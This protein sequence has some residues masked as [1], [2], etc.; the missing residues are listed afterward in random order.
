MS[1]EQSWAT[2]RAFTQIN[3]AALELIQRTNNIRS[4][5]TSTYVNGNLIIRGDVSAN[6]LITFPTSY[7]STYK[8]M[9]P[10]TTTWNV[11]VTGG[12]SATIAIVDAIGSTENALF[13][14][15]LSATVASAI[16]SD[17]YARVSIGSVDHVIRGVST[18]NTTN[19]TFDFSGNFCDAASNST[20]SISVIIIGL[21]DNT[22]VN[23][24]L[25]SINALQTGNTV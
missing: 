24:T 17:V 23:I 21:G 7:S 9:M 2:R 4:Q 18:D 15:E 14:V 10:E 25:K 8:D 22:T 11:D 12:V 16:E 19:I 6:N 13:H 20:D 3:T 5:G 1:I